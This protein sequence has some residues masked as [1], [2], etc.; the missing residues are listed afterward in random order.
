[1]I[2]PLELSCEQGRDLIHPS[3]IESLLLS[4]VITKHGWSGKR[5]RSLDNDGRSLPK[6]L[7]FGIVEANRNNAGARVPCRVGFSNS[8]QQD[9]CR[10]GPNASNIGT[11]VR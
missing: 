6:T 3:A 4:E 1:M 7:G 10:S 9:S 8:S 11:A 5:H 2:H